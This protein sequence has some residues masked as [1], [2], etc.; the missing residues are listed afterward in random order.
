M[1]KFAY[2]I[3]IILILAATLLGNRLFAS[4][5]I[6]P[7]TLVV[8]MVA[9]F[10]ILILVRPKGA[11]PKPVSDV[12]KKVRGDF[13]KDAF[14]DNDQLNA[15]FQAALKDYSGNCPK[16]ALGKLEKLASQCH[17]S[18]ETYAVSVAT[19]LCFISVNKYKEAIREYTRALGLH[20]TS[21]LAV[22][23]GSCHQRLGQLDKARD[24]YEFA[25]DLD[26]GNT[27]A[28]SNLATAYVADGD[29]RAGLEQ[30][31]LALEQDEKQA[32]A[33]AT[34]AIC[35][36]LLDD[37]LMHKHYTKLA[38]ENGYSEKKITDTVSALKKRG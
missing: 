27:E 24:S 7:T 25:L 23:L 11:A 34:A 5:S 30:A 17:T 13:A 31:M 6:S 21:D 19:A 16:A 35:H 20:P 14:A 15:K 26:A 37:Q 1:K 3:P 29:Y 33:L 4:G 8:A 36:G 2:F 9:V 32:S 22:S 38:V 12:E 18:Q 10:A 28:R